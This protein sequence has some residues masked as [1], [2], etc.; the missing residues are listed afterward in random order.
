MPQIRFLLC[1]CAALICLPGCNP[2]NMVKKV[3]PQEDQQAAT[4]CIDALRQKRFDALENTLAE[5][6]QGPETRATLE[7]M[8]NM[9]PAGTPDA[10]KLIGADIKVAGGSRISDITYQYSFGKRYFM[11]NCATSTDATSRHIVALNVHELEFS[12][13]EQA[14]FHL[15]DKSPAQLALL[16]AAIVFAALTLV[17]LVACVLEKGLQRKWLWV[18]FI[19]LGFGQLSVNWNSGV[20]SFSALHATLFSASAVS[21]GYGGWVIS[22]ALPVGAAVYLIRRFLNHRKVSRSKV[23]ASGPNP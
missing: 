13:D 3:A 22:I 11:V 20:W 16:L 4:E 5:G 17:A 21:R 7:R 18:I 6:L 2:E 19:L 12:I 10:V 1:L 14:G 15:K 23:V 8:A 9:L